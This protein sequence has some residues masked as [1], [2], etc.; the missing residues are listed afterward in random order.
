MASCASNGA[1]G[2]ED[3]ADAGEETT[4]IPLGGLDVEARPEVAGW[5]TARLVPVDGLQEGV[6]ARAPVIGLLVGNLLELTGWLR[7][8]LIVGRLVGPGAALA[9]WW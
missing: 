5:S 6:G 2:I 9:S 7:W 8:R 4:A 3:I 1:D